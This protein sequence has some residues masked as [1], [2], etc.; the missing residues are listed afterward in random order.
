M[1]NF[2]VIQTENLEREPA[3]WLADRC[4][5]IEC[6]SNSPRF[7]ELLGK[8]DGLCVRTYTQVDQKLLDKAPK[9]KVVGR[10]GVA[11][12]NIDI[13]SCRARG[14]EVVHTPGANTQAVVDYTTRIILDALRPPMTVTDIYDV[15]EWKKLRNSVPLGKQTNEIT[16]GVLGLGKIGKGVARVMTALGARVIYCDLL[17]IPTEQRFGAQPVD[18]PSLMSQSDIITVHVDSRPSNRHLL[19]DDSFSLAKDDLI[20]INTSRGFVVDFQSLA[21]FLVKHPASQAHLEVHDPEP[22]PPDYPVLGLRNVSLYPHIA[23][24][25]RTALLNMSWVV[26]DIWRVLQGES[27]DFPA[28]N[29]QA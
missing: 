10:A 12:E 5:L 29:S 21:Q 2:T 20:F 17:N 4:N 23:A 18:L 11:L 3:R 9:L 25:T 27:P 15:E 8:A 13:P 26:R 6:D 24:R 1:K 7:E 28:P 22:Y 19:S 14:V 16:I